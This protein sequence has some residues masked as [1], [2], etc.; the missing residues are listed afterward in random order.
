[1]KRFTVKTFSKGEYTLI[2]EKLVTSDSGQYK[3]VDKAG[4]G[5]D[6]A[7]AHLY[8]TGE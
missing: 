2:I 3:C 1:M 8:V 4:V 6:E 5:P 7:F